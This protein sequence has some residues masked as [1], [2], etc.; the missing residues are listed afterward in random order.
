M[1]SYVE[2]GLGRSLTSDLFSKPES[3][4]LYLFYKF[5]L[6]STLPQCIPSSIKTIL[7]PFQ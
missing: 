2:W 4:M 7:I 3:N 6:T 5:E 1:K